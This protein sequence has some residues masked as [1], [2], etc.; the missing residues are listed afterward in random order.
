MTAGVELAVPAWSGSLAADAEHLAAVAGAADQMLAEL[1]VK[2]ARDRDQAARAEEIH[3]VARQARA[4]FLA[5]HVD[6]V[7]TELTDGLRRRPRVTELAL[8]AADL[9]PGLTPTSEQLAEEAEL[10]Q[11]EKEGREIDQGVFLS[12]VLRSPT[13]GRHLMESMLMPTTRALDLLDAFTAEGLVELGAVRMERSDGTT[14]LTVH[15]AHCLNAEDNELIADMETAV[16]LV[17]LDPCT[18]VGVLRG[19]V[20]THPRYAGRR[21]F[22][23]GINLKHLHEGRISFTGFLMGR[24]LGYI[25]KIYRGL[26]SPGPD[27]WPHRFT[28]KPWVA[29]VDTF[30]IGGGAQLLLV[31][32]YVL[33]ASDAYFSLPAAQEGIVPGAGSFRMSRH[34]GARLTRQI[35]LSGSKIWASSAEGRLVFDEVVPAE[36]MDSALEVV[37]RRL[38][39][40]AVQANRRILHTVEE[41]F[42]AFRG[43]L[44][45][46]A[47]EQA[48][49]L[50]GDDVIAK[51]G[52]RAGR[53]L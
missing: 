52:R 39:S 5:E 30:A 18:R 40:P 11:A 10:T 33:A 43:Y 3:R 31:F 23:A 14:Q 29:A 38:D 17:L 9:F 27:T 47:F 21:V 35:L 16:D 4:A 7:Y 53:S 20:M 1:P 15:N 6:Q 32:D 22:S 36:A 13:A 37:V 41:P 45:E 50:Y 48:L 46:F 2:P 28:H 44:A 51:V 25:H 8:T 26:L 24:E 19:G 42:D 34:T 49:R 12:A